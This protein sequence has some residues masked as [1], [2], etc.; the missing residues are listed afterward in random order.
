VANPFA[1][2]EEEVAAI[3]KNAFGGDEAADEKKQARLAKHEADLTSM[4]GEAAKGVGSATLGLGRGA[5][6]ILARPMYAVAGAAEE[7]LSPKGTRQPITR[8]GKELLS[9]I[10]GIKGEKK[11][12][13]QVMEEAGVPPILSTS[14]VLPF[15]YS[16]TG[17]GAA[18]Q[19]GGPLDITAR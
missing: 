8:I 2:T 6:D 7:V 18:L 13:G 15:L 1:L 14:D 10:G 17:K 12:F 19:R 4:L 3:H 5:I 16:E 9:G 11:A